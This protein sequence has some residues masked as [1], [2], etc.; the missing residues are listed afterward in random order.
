M[1][2]G[3]RRAQR[4]ASRTK[5]DMRD[6]AAE[7]KLYCCC[8]LG[9]SLIIAKKAKAL[10]ALGEGIEAEIKCKRVAKRMSYDSPRAAWNSVCN[11]CSES[12]CPG[13]CGGG[14]PHQL[15]IPKAVSPK[16]YVCAATV[17]PRMAKMAALTLTHIPSR[18]PAS[19]CRMNLWRTVRLHAKMTTSPHRQRA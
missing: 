15:F 19:S 4:A 17:G 1:N 8:C 11:I 9:P 6:R 18:L 2:D 3:G 7:R 10:K 13:A 14:G 12:T 5:I 16:K